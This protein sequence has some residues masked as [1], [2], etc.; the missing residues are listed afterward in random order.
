M[1]DA[2][3]RREQEH[4]RDQ[5][6]VVHRLLG[7]EPQAREARP[8]GLQ[9][10][11]SAREAP[12]VD[13]GPVGDLSEGQGDDGEIES[14][15]TQSGQSHQRSHPGGDHRR[16]EQGQRVREPGPE[17]E[18]RRRVRGDAKVRGV[19]DRML[20]GVTTEHVP[21]RSGDHADENED[22]HVQHICARHRERQQQ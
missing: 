13:H 15:Q 5:R 11:G 21:A 8:R 10:A 12:P 16:A 3:G 1:D 19:P 4:G 6:Q 2:P 7:A 20:A 9:S 14:V 22:H 18:Q 17:L